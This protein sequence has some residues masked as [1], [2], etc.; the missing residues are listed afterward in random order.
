MIIL[1]LISLVLAFA[2]FVD[3]TADA[4]KVGIVF[5]LISVVLFVLRID[6]SMVNG[7]LASFDALVFSACNWIAEIVVRIVQIILIT[8]FFLFWGPFV[9]LGKILGKKDE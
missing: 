8:C 7:L 6:W 1:A 4:R 9:L 5:L 3:G 2:L